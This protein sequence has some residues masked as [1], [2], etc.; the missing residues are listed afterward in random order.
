MGQIVFL[1]GQFIVRSF[2]DLDTAVQ[3]DLSNQL[4]LV[5]EKPGAQVV[6]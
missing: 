5:N 3:I 6:N 2:A 4:R 1:N